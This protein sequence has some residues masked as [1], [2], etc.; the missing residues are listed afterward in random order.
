MKNPFKVFSHQ[1]DQK[2]Q[3][4]LKIVLSAQ[5]FMFFGIM[6]IALPYFNLYC[7]HK[8]LSGL[9]IGIIGSS[10]SL[11]IILFSLIWGVLADRY[12][13]RRFLYIL[14]QFLGACF[15]TLYLFADS[16]V[17]ILCVT[18]IVSIFYAPLISFMEA[19][20]MDLVGDNKHAYGNIRLWGSIQFILMVLIVG[21]LL[22]HFPYFIII[23]M[24]VFGY[25]IQAFVAIT[26]PPSQ[27]KK[28]KIKK[29]SLIVFKKKNLILYL[30]SS[31]LMLV[32]HGTYYAF[33]SIH[34]ELLGAKSNEI[35]IYWALGSIAEIF[36]MF[37]SNRIFK[38]FQVESVLLFSVIIAAIRWLLMFYTTK[39]WYIIIIQLLHAFTYGTFHI[40]GI[41]YIDRCMSENTK[42]TGQAVNNAVSYGLGLMTGSF[43]NGYLFEAV[44]THHAFIFSAIVA[45]LAGGILLG[46]NK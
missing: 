12:Q 17:S 21:E 22:N 20:T 39:V 25:F 10:R 27:K 35:A 24:I 3:T 7:Y 15:C 32:S 33:S 44:G 28:K 29:T 43:I 18:I 16:F 5:Y 1:Q 34:L 9:E 30:A 42:T 46:M 4:H 26:V 8:K 13:N 6:G 45:V 2:T 11:L 19:F 40:A 31:F 41:L 38:R 14:C 37:N 36:V 23:Q